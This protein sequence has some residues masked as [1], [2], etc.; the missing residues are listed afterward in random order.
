MEWRDDALQEAG[1]GCMA[2]GLRGEKLVSPVE[3]SISDLRLTA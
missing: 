3:W 2:Q 1:A